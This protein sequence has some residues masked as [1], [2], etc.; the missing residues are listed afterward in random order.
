MD[1]SVADA[2]AVNPKS[3]KPLLANSVSRFLINGKPAVIN[4]LKK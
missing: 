1:A 2:P 4:G 3:A